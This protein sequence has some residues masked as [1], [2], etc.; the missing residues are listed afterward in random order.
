MSMIGEWELLEELGQGGNGVVWRA[1]RGSQ[2]AALKVLSK[3]DPQIES[4]LRFKDE[5]SLL[6]SLGNQPG[7]LPLIDASI[8]D[9]PTKKNRAWLAMPVATGIR[10]SIGE[11][12]SLETIVTAMAEVAIS[13]ANLAEQGICHRDIKPENL[14]SYQ[15]R[16]VVGDFGLAGF[17]GKKDIT[18]HGRALGPRFYIAPEMVTDPINA[19]GFPADV[20]SLGKTLWVLA[21]GQN[22]PPPLPLQAATL[23]TALVS[24]TEHPRAYLLD[25]LLERTTRSMPSDRPTMREVADDLS[26]WLSPPSDTPHI[27]NVGDVAHRL[28]IAARPHLDRIEMR[29][30]SQKL[31]EEFEKTILPPLEH[32]ASRLREDGLEFHACEHNKDWFNAISPAITGNF[33]CKVYVI[34]V[35]LPDHS[36]FQLSGGIA[37]MVLED[38]KHQLSAFYTIHDRRSIHLA[39]AGRLDPIEIVWTQHY[40]VEP[41]S[42]YESYCLQQCIDG[43]NQEL[44]SALN[45]LTSL[46]TQE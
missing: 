13:L 10:T 40:V 29:M 17:P 25:R 8:P 30:R 21:T 33:G 5:I 6:R 34:L 43:L 2:I 18:E 23:Q 44:P 3:V 11:R 7:I 39:R 27:P 26:S 28:L 24:Y 37:V 20:W 1:K 32:I 35:C 14:Y 12:P 41:G 38:S 9:N 46:L 4:Y 31:M 22:F 19:S 42:A 16:S 15:G 45:R 36:G